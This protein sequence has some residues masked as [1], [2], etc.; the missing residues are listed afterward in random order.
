MTESEL[1]QLASSWGVVHIVPTL[2]I[3][4]NVILNKQAIFYL[5]NNE[6]KPTPFF[7]RMDFANERMELVLLTKHASQLPVEISWYR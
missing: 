6:N 7:P 3:I 4:G 5:A 1:N 2:A